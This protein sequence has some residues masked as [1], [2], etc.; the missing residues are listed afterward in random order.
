MAS[1]NTFWMW[2]LGCAGVGLLG[3]LACGGLAYFF[4]PS[5]IKGQAF[6]VAGAR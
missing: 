2:G 4:V 6:L 5:D 3:L 1:K